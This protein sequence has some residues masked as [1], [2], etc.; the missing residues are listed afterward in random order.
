[1][2]GSAL[3]ANTRVLPKLYEKGVRGV[4]SFTSSPRREGKKGGSGEG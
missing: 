2:G 3:N 4:I 1:M